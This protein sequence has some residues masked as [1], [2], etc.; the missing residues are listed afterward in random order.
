M[1][2]CLLVLVLVLSL[3]GQFFPSFLRLHGKS[4]DYKIAYTTVSWL[5][6]LPHPTQGQLFFVVGLNPPIRQGLTRY[7]FLVFTVRERVRACLYTYK[8]TC[9]CVCVCVCVCAR[10]DDYV[11]NRLFLGS[12]PTA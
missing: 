8:Y 11:L 10:C 4:Y 2:F 6:L 1:W 3:A 9:V 12:S 5:F 7:P